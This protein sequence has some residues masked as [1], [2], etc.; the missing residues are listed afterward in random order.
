MTVAGRTRIGAVIAI[1]A[2]VAFSARDREPWVDG[3]S[4]VPVGLAVVV[5]AAVPLVPLVVVAVLVRGRWVRDRVVAM[6]SLAEAM[7]AGFAAMAYSLVDFAIAESVGWG[8]AVVTTVVAVAVL[9]GAW[10][11][12]DGLVRRR[13]R[14]RRPLLEL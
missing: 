9:V 3:V 11:A 13:E 2:V 8:V 5:W 14:S 7:W 4:I 1:A 10:F 12:E 6:F